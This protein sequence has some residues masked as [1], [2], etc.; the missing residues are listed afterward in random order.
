MYV[1]EYISVTSEHPMLCQLYLPPFHTDGAIAQACEQ[2][3]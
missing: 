2:G 3:L 1:E